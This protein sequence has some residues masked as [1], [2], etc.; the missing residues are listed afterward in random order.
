MK[1]LKAEKR[2]IYAMIFA[3]SVSDETQTESVKD[4]KKERSTRQLFFSLLGRP[5]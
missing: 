5:L 4:K 3:V 2:T 1:K